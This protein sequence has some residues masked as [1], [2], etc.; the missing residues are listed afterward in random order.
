ML[1]YHPY[2]GKKPS[3]SIIHS[4]IINKR[5]ILVFSPRLILQIL[6]M[7]SANNYVLIGTRIMRNNQNREQIPRVGGVLN[8]TK[9]EEAYNHIKRDLKMGVCFKI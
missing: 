3:K 5:F 9:K 8:Y 4:Q 1:K 7:S 2:K 6:K